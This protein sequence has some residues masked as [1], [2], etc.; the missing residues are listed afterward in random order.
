MRPLCENFGFRIE[1]KEHITQK[2]FPCGSFFV[3]FL[4]LL[5]STVDRALIIPLPAVSI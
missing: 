1:S 5:N 4:S 2:H 3:T